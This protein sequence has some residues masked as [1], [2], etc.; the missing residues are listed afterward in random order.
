MKPQENLIARL[1]RLIY[2]VSMAA[3]ISDENFG[4][5]LGIALKYKL[6]AM[7]NL[8][9]T[10]ERL[11]VSGM[12]RRYQLLFSNPLARS[13]VPEDSWVGLNYIFTPNLPANVLEETQIAGNLS[14]ITSAETQLSVLSIVSDVKSEISRKSKESDQMMDTFSRNAETGLT[15][16]Q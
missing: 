7:S 6:L 13:K 11:F 16:G 5:S 10:K 4:T 3:N 1:E 15:D 9:K 2:Q 12:N 14:G 8:E